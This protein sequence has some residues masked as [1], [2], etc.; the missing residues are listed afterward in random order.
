MAD[1]GAGGT[2]AAQEH[3]VSHLFVGSRGH[4]PDIVTVS[5]LRATSRRIRASFTIAELRNRLAN[6]L[7]RDGDGINTPQL[8]LVRFDP[9]LGMGDLL[10]AVRIAEEGGRWD[11]T[12][13]VLQ[14]AS[15]CRYCTLPVTLT[16]PDINKHA[17]KTAYRLLARVL[18]Q[19]MVVGRHVDFGDGS[20]LQILRLANH[21]R[22]NGKVGAI[23][24]QAG[25]RLDVNPSLP[26]ALHLYR[27]HRLQHDPPVERSISHYE[28]PW[29][30]S[31]LEDTDASLSSFAKAMILHHFSWTHQINDTSYIL[32]NRRVG[33][34]RLDGLLT[35]SPHTP[36]AGCTT[37]LSWNGNVRT[38]VLTD[39]SHTFVAWV[40]ILWENFGNARVRVSTTEAPARASGAFK[41]RFPVTTRLA[42]VALGRV[43][44][45]VFDGQVEDQLQDDDDSD[46]HGGGWDDMDD[47]S[48]DD[49]DDGSGGK[50]DGVDDGSGEGSEGE[51]GAAEAPT[52]SSAAAAAAAAASPQAVAPEGAGGSLRTTAV[53]T[54]SQQQ[55]EGGGTSETSTQQEDKCEHMC[56]HMYIELRNVISEAGSQEAQLAVL[57]DRLQHLTHQDDHQQ[58]PVGSARVSAPAAGGP[59]ESSRVVNL[60][61]SA[62][63]PGPAHN[64]LMPNIASHFYPQPRPILPPHPSLFAAQPSPPAAPPHLTAL[65]HPAV[66]RFGFESASPP[67]VLTSPHRPAPAPAHRDMMMNQ[68]SP[69]QQYHIHAGATGMRPMPSPSAN[70]AGRTDGSRAAQG[71]GSQQRG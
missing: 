34:G 32:L 53:R 55:V 21:W 69:V 13:E 56:E 65:P 11:E 5:R 9:S 14:W 7:R 36:V 39:D 68:P 52:L 44:P 46:G 54:A 28:G 63:T 41:D 20:C 19:L 29:A 51:G 70:G 22:G 4:L 17:N 60:P 10:A 16:S 30:L 3:P 26:R 15:Q 12:R 61:V 58:A 38:L 18:A 23:K 42:R 2:M 24:D 49:S 67:F 48:D 40:S 33:G 37:T 27:Q 71:K 8:Q 47:D 64:Y 31:V 6:S 59:L 57:R 1:V 62:A 66:G 45:Y 43:A 50:G 25:F 35:Q